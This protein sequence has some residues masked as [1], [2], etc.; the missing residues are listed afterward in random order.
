MYTVV[1]GTGTLWRKDSKEE[2]LQRA[3]T[4]EDLRE[5]LIEC[6]ARNQFDAKE[7]LAPVWSVISDRD[8]DYDEQGRLIT[9][10]V[11][12]EKD[13]VRHFLIDAFR[14]TEDEADRL[15]R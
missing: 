9:A 15:L 11:S 13:D 4:Y 7:G 12:F 2:I 8:E 5:A 3:G 1:K 10:G 6:S 14:L